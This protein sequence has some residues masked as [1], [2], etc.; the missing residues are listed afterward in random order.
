[1]SEPIVLSRSTLTFRAHCLK[2]AKE[3]N[4]DPLWQQIVDEMDRF[5][6]GTD[7]PEPQDGPD[8]FGDD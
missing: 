6:R 2:H 4:A 7:E 1:M 5:A 3:P 8:L